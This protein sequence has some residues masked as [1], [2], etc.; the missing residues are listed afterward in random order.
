MLALGTLVT[1]SRQICDRSNTVEVCSTRTNY[2][3]YAIE[4]VLIVTTTYCW[5][6]RKKMV[7]KTRLSAKAKA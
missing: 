4:F 6:L 7:K 3:L 5:Y 1:V 2:L